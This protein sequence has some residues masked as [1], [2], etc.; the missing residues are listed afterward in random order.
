MGWLASDHFPGFQ[1]RSES[2][3]GLAI[4]CAFEC[5]IQASMIMFV[6]LLGQTFAKHSY[7]VGAPE[8]LTG[9]V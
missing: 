5:C 3:I 4:H 9:F 1:R 2:N 8:Q 7:A 6:P